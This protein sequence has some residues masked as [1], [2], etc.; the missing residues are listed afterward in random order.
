MESQLPPG[1]YLEL[2]PDL[3]VLRRC[4]KGDKRDFVAA[5][6]VRGATK[7]SLEQAA[8]EDYLERISLEFVEPKP[9]KKGSDRA[10]ESSSV[11]LLLGR[12]ARSNKRLHNARTQSTPLPVYPRACGGIGRAV[13]HG[14]G[15]LV[16][17]RDLPPLESLECG[18]IPAHASVMVHNKTL[19]APL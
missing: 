9:P 8:W 15:L 10:T 12:L 19:S 7:E 11:T 16:A 5:F 18:V 6:S 13:E 17:V 4:G 2:D 1:Y 14:E 3:L